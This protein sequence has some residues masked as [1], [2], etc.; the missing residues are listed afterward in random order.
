MENKHQ[1]S[2]SHFIWK[3]ENK[4][5]THVH[6]QLKF[7]KQIN[8]TYLLLQYEKVE[9]FKDPIIDLIHIWN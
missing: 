9:L 4:T 5:A 3:R 2:N 8:D 1:I 7:D 6:V